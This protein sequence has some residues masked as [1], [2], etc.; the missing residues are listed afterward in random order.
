M[1]ILKSVNLALAFALELA[2]LAAFAAW[3]YAS[4]DQAFIKILLGAGLAVVA[5]VLWGVFAAPKSS[6][7]LRGLALPAFK[8]AFFALA[9]LALVALDRVA[10]GA[11]LAALAVLNLALAYAWQQETL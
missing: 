8:L 4:S 7:R 3:G 6:R 1:N 9:A 11:L 2:A 5:A 10:L